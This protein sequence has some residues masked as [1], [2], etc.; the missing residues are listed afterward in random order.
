MLSKMPYFKAFLL[1][2]IVKNKT[3]TSRKSPTYQGLFFIFLILQRETDFLPF[4]E[5]T[6]T[7]LHIRYS[8]SIVPGGFPVQSY[9][10]RFTPFTSFTIRLVTLFNISQGICA[11]SAVIKSLVFTARN[12][13]A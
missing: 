10:T 3:S 13:T 8:N 12:A 9:I 5:A 7:L 6:I 1:H 4:R 11:A 2:A